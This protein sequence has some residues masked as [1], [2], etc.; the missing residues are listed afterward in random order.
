MSDNEFFLEFGAQTSC[1]SILLGSIVA[2]MGIFLAGAGTLI[3]YPMSKTL[4]E[5]VFVLPVLLF[6]ATMYLSFRMLFRTRHLTTA[7]Q[8]K[9]RA[10]QI[11]DGWAMLVDERGNVLAREAVE[12]LTKKTPL[13]VFECWVNATSG[14]SGPIKG[15]LVRLRFPD[16]KPI[17][18]GIHDQ[19]VHTTAHHKQCPEYIVSPNQ[20]RRLIRE[21]GIENDEA[22]L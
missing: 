13:A 19:A 21:L 11:R 1:S 8:G 22:R 12:H 2:V 6:L 15:K 9:A 4:G 5:W 20:W 7:G 14:W 10:L 3:L 17:T 18:I 16:L